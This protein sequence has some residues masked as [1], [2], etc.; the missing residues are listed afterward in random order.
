MFWSVL[1]I[2]LSIAALISY[3]I[4]TVYKEFHKN[5]GDLFNRGI[6]LNA[7]ICIG[8]QIEFLIIIAITLDLYKWG[9]FLATTSV[10]GDNYEQGLNTK[11]KSLVVVLVASI[12]LVI[13]I[14]ITFTT[15]IILTTYVGEPSEKDRINENWKNYSNLVIS[16]LYLA[17]LIIYIF[18]LTL[19]ISRLKK[20]YGGYYRKLRYKLLTTAAFLIITLAAKIFLRLIFL[21]DEILHWFI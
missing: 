14:S 7:Y 1:T 3:L 21:N 18:T 9:L 4:I 15:G 6:S 5:I 8:F 2:T 19:L 11:K 13:A 12:V 16:G 10:G 20:L 17:F